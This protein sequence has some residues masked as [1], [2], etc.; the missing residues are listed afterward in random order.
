MIDPVTGEIIDQKD[1]AERLL[2][3]AKEQGVSLVG[4]GGLLNQLTKNVLETA[5]NAEL[6]EHLGHDHG[7][8]PIAENMRNGTRVKTVL[9][10]IGPVEIE[11]PRDRDGSFEPVIVPKRKR[12]LDGVD[13]IVLSLTARGLTTGEVAAHFDEVYGAKVS[14]DT[15]SRITALY[16]VIF[17]DAIVVKV[18]DGQVRNTP[19][20]VVMG[21]T[22]SGERDILGIW[23]GDGAE[24]ARFWLQVFTEL[25]N[26]GV[27]DVLIA[28]CDGLKGLPEAINT[29]WE[30]TVVQQCIV[31][32][33]RNSFRYAGRQHRDAIV[34][35]LK[36]VYT[37]PSEAA[38]KDRFEEFAAEWG[39]RYPAIIQLW[40]TSW[41]E[42]VPFLE[43]DVE[44]RRVICTTNA[45][46]SINA[47]YR[48][49]VR[50]RG[51]FP[52][53]AAA[54]KCLYLVTRS[55]DPTGGG[56]ARWVMRWKPAL[57]AF[58]ITFAGQ[59]ERTTH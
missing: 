44:I 2:A 37:A 25:K 27:E 29:T 46:E 32:L 12:R 23:A 30:Q 21:V 14:K 41:A 55:L 13:Q 40:R 59:F 51:H 33:I 3:Q 34:R 4:P 8:T 35:S 48:R 24:G 57:N 22:T 9:T 39:E 43:Y 18:R 1:L 20:Y 47:R 5:L 53:E 52:N 38:A 26:R 16:P 56:R 42:F 10:E 17:V 49:A 58:A 6:T 54:S 36:P 50:A 19:F 15:I 31:H 11:V 7:G 28:V 45:I